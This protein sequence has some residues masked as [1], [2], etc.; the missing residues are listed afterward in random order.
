M[1]KTW[2]K[3]RRKYALNNIDWE[4]ENWNYRRRK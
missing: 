1:I 2:K 4:T 3:E